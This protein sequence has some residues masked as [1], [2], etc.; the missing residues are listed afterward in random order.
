MPRQQSKNRSQGSKRDDNRENTRPDFYVKQPRPKSPDGED[1]GF[2]M[3]GAAWENDK[4]G[5][6]VKLN[7][8]QIVSRGFYLFPAED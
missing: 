1:T 3:L 4:G 6:Y 7:G 2:E 5:I 8:T